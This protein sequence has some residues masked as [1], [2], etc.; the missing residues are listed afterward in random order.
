MPQL[1]AGLSDRLVESVPNVS[2]GRRLDVVDRGHG[3]L[4]VWPI[5]QVRAVDRDGE[6]AAGV[7]AVVREF[8]PEY[9]RDGRIDRA[10]LGEL[11]FNDPDA[12]RRLNTRRA[13]STRTRADR[14]GP[15]DSRYAYLTR[16]Y[17]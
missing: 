11:V 10:G 15:S 7:E 1:P 13:D 8:G 16:S 5:G 2:E 17:D 4:A 3:R 14:F 12:R 6:P 9:A